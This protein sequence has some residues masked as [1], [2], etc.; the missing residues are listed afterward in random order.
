MR[1]ASKNSS[2]MKRIMSVSVG[3]ERLTREF[4]RINFN[5]FLFKRIK[6]LNNILLKLLLRYFVKKAK[7]YNMA[8]K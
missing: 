4:N 2:Q 3:S 8:L 5:I 6:F 7:F 1:A